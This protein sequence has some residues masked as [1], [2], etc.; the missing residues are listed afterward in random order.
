MRAIARGWRKIWHDLPT[1]FQ[2]RGSRRCSGLATEALIA[3]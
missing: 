3:Y 2:V 1:R